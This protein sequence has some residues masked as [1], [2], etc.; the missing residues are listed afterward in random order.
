MSDYRNKWREQ[1]E[2]MEENCNKRDFLNYGS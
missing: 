2:R 1:F